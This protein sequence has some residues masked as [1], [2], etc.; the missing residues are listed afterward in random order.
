M[1]YLI[2]TYEAS[3]NKDFRM[4]DAFIRNINDFAAYEPYQVG[5]LEE[6][7]HVFVVR[8]TH[9]MSISSIVENMY[10]WDNIVS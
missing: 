7:L 5:A 1:D 2:G 8:K 9:A 3:R 6:C 4:Y 10:I